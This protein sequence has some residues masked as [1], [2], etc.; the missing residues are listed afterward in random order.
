VTCLTLSSAADIYT[1]A[2]G[3]GVAF[4][5]LILLNVFA[6]ALCKSAAR[7][8]QLAAEHFALLTEGPRVS[9]PEN[10]SAA[11]SAQ[12]ESFFET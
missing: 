4:V 12:R 9:I 7:A 6:I 3:G 2:F 5:L 10:N 11:R 1:W 8:D